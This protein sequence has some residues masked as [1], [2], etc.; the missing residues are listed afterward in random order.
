MEDDVEL[1]LRVLNDGESSGR[2]Y[3]VAGPESLSFNDFIEVLGRVQGRR[4]RPLHVPAPLALLGARI[5]GRL[6]THPFVNVDQVMAFLQD[7]EVDIEP[8]RRDLSWDPRPLDEGLAE[9]FGG[10]T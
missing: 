1:G 9:L 3:D 8:A 10:T 5:L 6:Q 7:T 4:A 2:T